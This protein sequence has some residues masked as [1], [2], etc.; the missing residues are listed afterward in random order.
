M[1]WNQNYR[2]HSLTLHNDVVTTETVIEGMV[3]GSITANPEVD[4]RVATGSLF[5]DTASLTTLRPVG[6][7]VTQ[8]I[9]KA[10]D[11]IGFGGPNSCIH[12]DVTGYG[13]KLWFYLQECAGPATVT[14]P[15]TLK[16]RVYTVKE[17]L[18]VPRQL[19]VNH[20]GDATISYDI[21]AAYDGTVNPVVAA[22]ALSTDLP[23]LT[24]GGIDNDARW[25]MQAATVG[26][27]TVE[28]KRSLTIDFG[29]QTSSEGA[30]S[31]E[32]DSVTTL[33]GLLQQIRVQGVNPLWFETV[34]DIL[35]TAVTHANT[36][37]VL[38]KRN[39]ADATA[40]HIRINAA[41]LVNW[42]TIVSGDAESPTEAAFNIDCTVNESDGAN[43]IIAITNHTL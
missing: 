37:F 5:A 42:D 36:N 32:F 26:G 27:V 41:G 35:G 11:T 10:I 31:D 4:R 12:S 30:D 2:L 39:T 8:N 33:D 29:A 17:G 43:P 13:L 19:Q 34:A 25:T 18:F 3:N 23:D 7:F 1:T 40:E 20:R 38:R 24:A 9:A 14:A 21:L 28:G 15:S 22:D 16:H 6:S